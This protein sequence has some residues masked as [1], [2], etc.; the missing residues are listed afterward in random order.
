MYPACSRKFALLAVAMLLLRAFSSVTYAQILGFFPPSDS[1][2]VIG[3]CTP[4]SLTT[5]VIDVV[6]GVDTIII[7]PMWDDRMYAG[8]PFGLQ[9]SRCFFTV[10]DNVDT[11]QYQLFMTSFWPDSGTYH[12]ITFDS[13]FSVMGRFF[14]C[15]RVDSN[16]STVD[17]VEAR[18][19]AD[20]VG[21]VEPA[22]SSL[23][24]VAR[25][26]ENFPNPFNASTDILYYLNETS[27]VTL[28]VYNMLGQE[29][30]CL[31]NQVMPSGLYTARFMAGDVSTGQYFCRLRT[32]DASHTRRITCIK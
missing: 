8:A 22:L 1:I 3:S 27:G 15:L 10:A 25:V 18:F 13:T 30:A 28:I 11:N 16:G 14:L 2:S 24:T 31:V 23:S 21:A 7:Q 6:G 19:Y 4:P 29:I 9:I 12:S 26:L 17:S 32:G 5:H 20:A